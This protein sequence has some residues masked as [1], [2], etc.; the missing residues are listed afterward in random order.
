MRQ[1]VW[2]LLI[3]GAGSSY[4]A[5]IREPITAGTADLIPSSPFSTMGSERFS[6][7]GPDFS[8][9][10]SAS[11]ISPNY[12][13][14]PILVCYPGSSIYG[15]GGDIGTQVGVPI[16]GSITFQGESLDYTALPQSSDIA[17]L[18]LPFGG[19]NTP[20]S[21]PNRNI[22]ITGPFHAAAVFR[23]A[24]FHSND[25]LQFEGQ[26]WVTLNL[27]LF[28]NPDVCCR[29]ALQSIHFDFVDVPE[30]N[31]AALV[32]ALLLVCAI[33]RVLSSK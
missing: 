32:A 2:M 15:L 30:P 24:D 27:T 33:G 26:G 8:Y 28:G 12:S 21:D 17:W 13:C 9:S 31:T 29:Y 5:F 18:T 6:I 23:N 4:A 3:F 25:L 11:Q 10:G 16:T 20:G 1:A 19:L 22:T 7:S 14:G